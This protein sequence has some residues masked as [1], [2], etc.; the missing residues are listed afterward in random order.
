[1]AAKFIFVFVAMGQGDCCMVRCP[2]GKVVVVDCGSTTNKWG[3]PNWV[4]EA[5]L[6]LR[7][8]D[9]AGGNGDK[10]DALVLTHSDA[11]H[12]NKV[13]SFFSETQWQGDLKMPSTGQVLNRPTARR[14]GIGKIY[15]SDAHAANA[16]LGNYTG[17]N[18]NNEVIGGT[19][20]TTDIY[21]VTINSKTDAN[22]SY[23]RWSSTNSF[24]AI[25]NPQPVNAHQIAGKRLTILSGKTEQ[26]DWS[27]SI[28]AGNVARGYGGVT[29]GAT[30]D[31]AK[32]LVTL[33]EVGGKKALL[34]GD[35]TF[36]TEKFLLD[37]H[38]ASD[39]LK[40]LEL[41]QIPHHGSR[42]AS[43]NKFVQM[44]KPQWVVA[45]VSFLEHSYRLPRYE[46]VID[47]WLGEIEGQNRTTNDHDVDYWTV[48]TED[49]ETIEDDDVQAKYKEW[50]NDGQNFSLVDWN[51]SKT[52]YFLKQPGNGVIALYNQQ[53][54][55]LFLY[56]E[57]VNSRLVLT[58]QKTQIFDLTANGVTHR[59]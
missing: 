55:G 33:F 17:G 20:S 30:A 23:R 27:V 24:G 15:L 35:A 22:N 2:D 10:V 51:D 32:S 13:V 3:N 31:N 37:A 1:M 29:D 41:V 54:G 14:I 28:V 48:E 4:A 56:R 36:S 49:G 57:T 58:S 8:G 44:T 47:R 9:W 6:L 7:H 45:S 38:Q 40:N 43:G 12:H 25:V 42:Y 11:D 50:T 53:K 21:E 34:C 26:T 39:L 18:L 5:M 46:Y 52:F 59:G 19:F 16:P